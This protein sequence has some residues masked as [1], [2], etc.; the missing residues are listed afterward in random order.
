MAVSMSVV[1]CVPSPSS[2]SIAASSAS[3]SAVANRPGAVLPRKSTPART[4]WSVNPSRAPSRISSSSRTA[5]TVE[6]A[7]TEPEVRN[8]PPTRR[9]RNPERMP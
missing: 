1:N 6:S 3:V 4:S 8:S 5:S 9:G 7:R 2:A